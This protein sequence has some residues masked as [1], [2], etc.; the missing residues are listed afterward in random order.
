MW[1]LL[2]QNQC[3]IDLQICL[4]ILKFDQTNTINPLINPVVVFNGIKKRGFGVKESGYG[5]GYKYGYG[6]YYSNNKKA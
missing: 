4:P 2:Y 6:A 1:D 5:Y 3:R